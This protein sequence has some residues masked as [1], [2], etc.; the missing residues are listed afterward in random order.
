MKILLVADI[1]G[2]A[3]DHKA[4]VLVNNLKH[5]VDNIKKIFVNNFDPKY[6]KMFDLIHFFGWLDAIDYYDKCTVGVSSFNYQ[7]KYWDIAKSNMNKFRGIG[8]VSK[9]LFDSLV[10]DNLNSNIFCIPNGVDEKIFFPTKKL[11]NKKLI[12]GWVGQPSKG[13]LF[14]GYSSV[15]N[16]YDQHGYTN[17]LLPLV[18]RFKENNK[19]EFKIFSRK[20]ID[21]IPHSEM[22]NFYNLCDIV[23]HTGYLTGTPNPIFEAAA[24]AK[25][26][27]CTK[28]GAAMDMIENGIN[29]YLVDCYTNKKEA[30]NTINKFEEIIKLFIKDRDF[31]KLM[32][33]K[34]RDIILKNWTWKKRSE[35]YLKF[36]KETIKKG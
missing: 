17:I 15:N 21:A 35:D 22:N 4:N 25:P 26:V 13:T 6:V 34:S 1:P 14:K 20:P 24:C 18:D 9:E 11:D 23:I 33:E 28:V 32:G 36:F 8:V 30:F 7:V 5:H 29:G 27:I 2:W 10:K 19:I 3:W 31:V 16:F 12:V